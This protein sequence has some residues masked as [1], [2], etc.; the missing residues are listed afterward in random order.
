M[1]APEQRPDRLFVPDK[2]SGWVYHWMNA[3]AGPQGDQNLYMAAWEGWEPAPMDPS[4]LP[5]GVLAA[6]QQQVSQAGGG[7]AHRRGDLVL[8]RMRQEAWE[9][10]IHAVSEATLKRQQSTLDTMV[11]QAQENAA[12]Q[13]RERGQTNIPKNLVF[14]EDIGDPT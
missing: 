1:T 13:L 11:L 3:A 6:A 12:R 7:T 10:N 9:K 14:S 4:K 8:Y 5:P 2:E